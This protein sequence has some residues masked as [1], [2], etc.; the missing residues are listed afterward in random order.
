MGIPVE[1]IPTLFQ[2]FAQADNRES[3]QFAGTGLGLSICRELVELHGGRIWVE[4]W[5][6]CAR[7]SRNLRSNSDILCLPL[8]SVGKGSKFSF[9]VPISS[10]PAP[11]DASA[12]VDD[13]PWEVGDGTLD[14]L[15]GAS[16]AFGTGSF[17]YGTGG[18]ASGRYDRL[19]SLMKRLTNTRLVPV[20]TCI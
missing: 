14:E 3:R 12:A 18:L 9:T 16:G 7:S 10:E 15:F 11:E 19:V 1:V 20:L 13:V 4:S 6:G 2:E 17:R 5:Y 8:H